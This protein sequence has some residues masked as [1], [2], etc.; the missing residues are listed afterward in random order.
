[1]FGQEQRQHVHGSELCSEALGGGDGDLFARTSEEVGVSLARDGGVDDVGDGK[2]LLAVLLSQALR[3]SGVG[4]FSRL[5]DG[6]DQ[7]ASAVQRPPATVFAGMLYIDWNPS[8][9]FDH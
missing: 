7:R 1:M 3:G 8:Q 4:G 9:L 5:G 2:R 6:D